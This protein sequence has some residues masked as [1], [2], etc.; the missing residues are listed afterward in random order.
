MLAAR[1]RPGVHAA[2]LP[3]S[4]SRRTLLHTGSLL[5]LG[6]ATQRSMAVAAAAK[7]VLV[8][9]GTG[10]EEMEAV[11]TIGAA[12]VEQAAGSWA[13][14]CLRSRRACMRAS[15]R[16]RAAASRRRGGGGVCGGRARRH[17]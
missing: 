1:I 17:M 14:R 10:T 3:S 15:G 6:L 2:A 4:L 5:P 12:R 16:R 11:I 7:S 9:V 13:V 8:P